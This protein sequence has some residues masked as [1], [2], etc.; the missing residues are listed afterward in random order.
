MSGDKGSAT[1]C[2]RRTRPDPPAV[3]TS[4]RPL[5]AGLEGQGPHVLS[6]GAL[7][8]AGRLVWRSAVGSTDRGGPASR[9]FTVWSSSTSRSFS[10]CTRSGSTGCTARCVRSSS[11]CSGHS[12]PVDSSSGGTSSHNRYYHCVT[13]TPSQVTIT[14]RHHPLQGL[15]LEVLHTGPRELVVRAPDGFSMRLPRAWMD[16]DGSSS[17]TSE[18][19]AVFSVDA[20]RALLEI[21]EALP[22]RRVVDEASTGE[23]CEGPEGGTLCPS[24]RVSTSV[25]TASRSCGDDSRSG[26]DEP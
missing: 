5:G 15:A 19:D 16:A 23:T 9:R 6:P 14:R 11:G 12:S 13:P 24:K 3:D 7:P 21:V 2:R 18:R 22:R 1:R 25:E 4:A 26:R 8:P 10:E 17:G 20:I